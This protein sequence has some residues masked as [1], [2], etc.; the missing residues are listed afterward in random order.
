MGG[1]AHS[2]VGTAEENEDQDN[3][4]V[5]EI[6]KFEPLWKYAKSNAK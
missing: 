6:I 5:L 2:Q 4:F 3:E 1:C